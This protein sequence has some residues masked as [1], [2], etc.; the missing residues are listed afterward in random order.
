M[1]FFSVMAAFVAG[2]ALPSTVNAEPPAREIQP[3]VTAK[4]QTA[5]VPSETDEEEV[6][7]PVRTGMTRYGWKWL[8]SRFDKD[9]NGR[10]TRRELPIAA[11]DF[12]RLDQTWDDVLTAIDFDWTADGLLCRQK[13]TTF[14]LFKAADT[15]SDGRLSAEEFQALFARMA[16]EKGYLDE[17]DLERFI[18]LPRVVKARKEYQ[19]RAS[20]ITFQ[21]DDQG[22]LPT[23]LPAPGSVAP[24]FELRSPDGQ[25]T[26]RLSSFRGKKPV[27]LIYGCL[28][29]GNYRTYSPAL[30]EL[31]RQRKDEV[32]FLRVYVRETHPS[33]TH[34]PTETNSKASI[35][36]QQPKTLEERC[37]VAE[38]FAADMKI[39]TPLVVDGIDNQVGKAYGGWPDRLYV[40]DRDGRVAYQGGPGPFAFN[41]REMEQSL[42]LLLLDQ[43]QLAS[44]SK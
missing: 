41:P 6:Y 12:S 27:V 38:R 21:Y 5:T 10:I 11:A 35:L 19:S 4:S 29:C 23:N 15:T 30:E 40:I 37:A 7:S 1:R 42:L 25:R 16:K 31:Y 18:F 39:E 24:D 32:E 26:V 28:T 2:L 22:Q 34:S 36:I 3:T 44:A 33:D 9:G 17:R 8:S 43:K 20:H 13:E 14:A